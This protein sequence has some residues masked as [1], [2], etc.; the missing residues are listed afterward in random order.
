[1]LLN[2]DKPNDTTTLHEDGC[3]MI[4]KPFGTTLK[5]VE[6]LGRDGGWFNVTS[7]TEARAVAQRELPGGAFISCQFCR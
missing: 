1:M 4:P 5:P 6:K 7:D 2:V 3:S